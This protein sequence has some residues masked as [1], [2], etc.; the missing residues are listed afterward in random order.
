ML[1]SL[2]TLQGYNIQAVDG[3]IGKV[4]GFFFDESTWTV[5]YLVADTGGWLFDRLALL[6]TARLGSPQWEDRV[7]AVR[8]TKEQVENSPPILADRPVS[9]QMEEKL[10]EFY[11]WPTYWT[12]ATA[13][14]VSKAVAKMEK[15]G[16]VRS[17]PHLRSTREVIGYDIHAVDGV[18]GHVEDFIVEDDT[19]AIRYMVVCTRDLQPGKSVLIAPAWVDKVGWLEQAVH[20]DLAQEA[21]RNSPEF[22]PSAPVNR[23]CEL[24]LYDYYGRPKYWTEVKCKSPATPVSA[25]SST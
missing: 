25:G 16:L 2:K 8:L 18:I 6:S 5:R 10:S 1:R 11:G 15:K 23:A 12:G 13:A 4:N 7:F 3:E 19:W 9:R 14:V 20:V 21:V 17:D 24:R 22:D